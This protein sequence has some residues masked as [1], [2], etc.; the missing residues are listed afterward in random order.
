MPH[1]ALAIADTLATLPP[2]GTLPPAA[3]EELAAGSR[4]VHY[5]RHQT[6]S[7]EGRTSEGMYVVVDGEVKCFLLSPG[8]AE[9]IIQLAGRGDSFGEEAAL[10]G[11]PQPVTTEATRDSTVVVIGCSALRRAMAAC[12]ALN[13]ALLGNLSTRMYELIENL[14]QCVQRTSTQRVA[15]Y[16]ARLAPESAGHCEIRLDTDKQTIAAQLNLTPE[17][18]SRVL[19]RLTRAG[20]IRPNGRR[21]MTLTDV[22]ML[23]SCAAG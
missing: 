20:V 10:L 16:L 8:G 11:R 14:Q 1:A 19:G 6:I 21:G 3:L 18:L 2:F 5:A 7:Q 12:P 4:V 22:R 13:A 23:R 9:K 15:H 17:T